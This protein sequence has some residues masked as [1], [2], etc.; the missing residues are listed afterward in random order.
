MDPDADP[1]LPPVDNGVS[2]STRSSGRSHLSDS[3]RNNP[4]SQRSLSTSNIMLRISPAA[5]SATFGYIYL[6]EAEWRHQD[7]ITT[8]FDSFLPGILISFMLILHLVTAFLSA[9]TSSLSSSMTVLLATTGRS[10]SSLSNTTTFRR[11]FSLSVTKLAHS[12][13][14]S[15]ATE[16][17]SSLAARPALSFM[18]TTRLSRPARRVGNLPTG[19]LNHIGKSWYTCPAP[20]S[21]KSKCHEPF[22]TTRWNIP[23]E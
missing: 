18:A 14:S 8:Y 13:V 23:P 20:T 5:G 22:G 4:P 10:D 3:L 1:D 11:P 6:A 15:V 17:K 7:A 9:G 12:L 19:W 2:T 21:L 16:M